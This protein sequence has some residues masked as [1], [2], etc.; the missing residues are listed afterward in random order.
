MAALGV[1]TV[2][3]KS[4]YGL[5]LEAELKLL[6]VVAELATLQPLEL[7]P[8]LLAAHIVPPEYRERPR[9]ATCGW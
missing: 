2:E 3:V 7:V 6:E 4:G 9:R 8:T 5:T 1:T